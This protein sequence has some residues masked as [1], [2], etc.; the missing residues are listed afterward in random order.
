MV[1]SE[2]VLN[3]W[4]REIA[5]RNQPCYARR[6]SFAAYELNHAETDTWQHGCSAAA[7]RHGTSDI[8]RRECHVIEVTITTAK[9]ILESYNCGSEIQR[10]SPC[11]TPHAI[12]RRLERCHHTART[13]LFRSRSKL[14]DLQSLA[15][16]AAACAAFMPVARDANV[17]RKTQLADV[18]DSAL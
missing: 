10:R 9:L 8:G 4:C 16:A 5:A 2:S 17:L 15:L 13:T 7:I 11:V 18:I 12:Q 3:Q 6:R 14:G 1:Q